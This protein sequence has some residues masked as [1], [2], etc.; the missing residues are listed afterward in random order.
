MERKN[1]KK[2][3]WE[4]TEVI[5]PMLSEKEIS[6]AINKKLAYIIVELEHNPISYIN[7]G[8]LNEKGCI[9]VKDAV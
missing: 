3:T 4:L 5:N 7:V 9:N 6:D 8:K 2:W 1:K